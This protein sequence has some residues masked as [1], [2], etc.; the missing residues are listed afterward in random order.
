[1]DSAVTLYQNGKLEKDV[2]LELTTILIK[3]TY[4]DLLRNN[5]YAV[6]LLSLP[7]CFLEDSI[8]AD[9]LVLIINRIRL[10]YPENNLPGHNT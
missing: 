8:G 10:T 4:E 1:M 3:I 7:K 2:K 6:W 5:N 9:L